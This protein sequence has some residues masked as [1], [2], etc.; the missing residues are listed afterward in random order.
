MAQLMDNSFRQEVA[1]MLR[2]RIFTRLVK[3]DLDTLVD[4]LSMVLNCVMYRFG[5]A[6]E[7]LAEHRAGLRKNDYM[8]V[9]GFVNMLL[10]FID[11]EGGTKK[12]HANLETLHDIVAKK[13]APN[14]Y[15]VCNYQYDHILTTNGEEVQ[16]R[17]DAGSAAKSY[18]VENDMTITE[19]LFDFEA[20]LLLLLRTIDEISNKLYVNWLQVQPVRL[21]NFRNTPTYRECFRYETVAGRA[22]LVAG[23]NAEPA[24]HDWIYYA[25]EAAQYRGLSIGDVYAAMAHGLYN[26]VRPVKWL[27]Y[28]GKFAGYRQPMMYVTHLQLGLPGVFDCLRASKAWL[29]LDADEKNAVADELQRYITSLETDHVT[30]PTPHSF[31]IASYLLLFMSIHYPGMDDVLEQVNAKRG[32]HDQVRAAPD[33]VK[34][35]LDGEDEIGDAAD[36]R[37]LLRDAYLTD[38]ELFQFLNDVPADHIYSFLLQSYQRLRRSWYGRRIFDLGQN[39][40]CD[41]AGEVLYLRSRSGRRSPMSYKLMYNFAKSLCVRSLDVAGGTRLYYSPSYFAMHSVEQQLFVW[42]L[43]SQHEDLR[44]VGWPSANYDFV[45]PG[46]GGKRIFINLGRYF[47]RSYG[48]DLSADDQQTLGN[49]MLLTGRKLVRDITFEY[50]IINGLLSEVMPV[51]RTPSDAHAQLQRSLS[52]EAEKESYYWITGRPYADLPPIIC[53]NEQTLD[54]EPIS[55]FQML[56]RK[57]EGMNW[58][59]FY[60]LNWVSQ[61]SFFHH[62]INNRVSFITGA[63]G[64]GKS[65]QVPKLYLYGQLMVDHRQDGAVIVSQPRIAPTINNATRISRELGVPISMH[66]RAFGKAIKTDLGYVQYRTKEDKHVVAHHFGPK[67]MVVT[68]KML[69]NDL[70][71][72][73]VFK[74]IKE[75]PGSEQV[76]DQDQFAYSAHNYYDAIMV[77][78]AHE[79]NVNMDLS[80]TLG[81]YAAYH[82]NALRLAIVSATMDD[83]EPTYRKYFMPIND[84]FKYPL[85]VNLFTTPDG[86]SHNTVDRRIH[87]SAPGHSTMYKIKEEYAPTDPANYAEAE[88]RAEAHLMQLL[89]S[90]NNGDV[91]MFSLGEAEI[92]DLVQRLNQKMPDDTICLPLY[93]TLPAAWKDVFADLRRAL[94][95][96]TTRRETLFEY[97]HGKPHLPVQAGTYKRAIIVATN[98]AE[99]SITIDSLRYVIDT[100][101]VKVSK[102]DHVTNASKLETRLITEASRLQ[103]KGRVGRVASG[104]VYYTYA[105]GSRAAVQREFPIC[106]QNGTDYMYD[107]L[108]CADNRD[109]PFMCGIDMQLTNPTELFK[110]FESEDAD[111][112]PE[113][114]RFLQANQL[115]YSMV[116]LQY[117]APFH[118]AKTLLQAQVTYAADSLHRVLLAEPRT[119]RGFQLSTLFDMDGTFYLVHPD[120]QSIDRH[121]IWHHLQ[122]IKGHPDY[123]SGLYVSTRITMFVKNLIDTG[124]VYDSS[125][126]WTLNEFLLAPHAELLSVNG[127]YL[128]YV[129][130][131]NQSIITERVSLKKSVPGRIISSLLQDLSVSEDHMQNLAAIATCLHSFCYGVDN[132]VLPMLALLK[133]CR[134][135]LTAL[136]SDMALIRGLA[137][138]PTSDLDV[139]LALARLVAPSLNAVPIEDGTMEAVQQY[140]Q[141]APRV[142]VDNFTPPIDVTVFEQ[143]GANIRAGN[144]RR[145][146]IDL[147][148]SQIGIAHLTEHAPRLQALFD[149]LHLHIAPAQFL[150][151]HLRLL[152]TL[153]ASRAVQWFVDNVHVSRSEHQPRNVLKSFMHGFGSGFLYNASGGSLVDIGTGEVACRLPANLPYGVFGEYVAIL[154]KDLAPGGQEAQLPV[155]VH[156]RTLVETCAPAVIQK[157][158]D[159]HAYYTDSLA[160]ALRGSD[161][162]HMFHTRYDVKPARNLFSLQ[163]DQ[164]QHVERALNIVRY[165]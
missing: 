10:P 59:S 143:I 73:P 60:S 122:G 30:H 84:N 71:R 23:K 69:L 88:Q 161:F 8:D 155:P 61:I 5:F 74:A 139:V 49:A 38:N 32:A 80:L 150:R 146:K 141:V 11:D 116:Y 85:D 100:G 120:E 93:S 144:L 26:D 129:Y 125:L 147:L 109:K 65:T 107:L 154:G 137:T 163:N 44:R 132:A 99:A 149:Q 15:A 156:P 108:D 77:D 4:G 62:Y 67:L 70:V 53:R 153:S 164:A 2:Q 118:V 9:L 18:D 75:A 92:K 130:A 110:W 22:S 56:L 17:L 63:T 47:K 1:D 58:M 123:N 103:R 51:E 36:I 45:V 40:V 121:P 96:V 52:P 140:R 86:E 34:R 133:L 24:T 160:A 136:A 50:L 16:R 165:T 6:E 81:R 37:R 29:L 64:T 101:Y 20:N 124:L 87:I 127:M 76:R 46:S 134:F 48:V 54:H 151:E 13:S 78:E 162:S 27:L 57:S 68:D 66:S 102:Y 3:P 79:H 159:G 128:Q 126:A 28:D 131:T 135:S 12:R 119:Q 148:T 112:V 97:I 72:S 98:I 55:Y 83:D 90:E 82:N 7:K 157:L 142:F 19:T 35:H 95:T 39:S 43:G 42:L 113:Q 114:V 115:L 138:A 89:R 145:L 158:F 33:H 152:K 21:S 105:R 104:T 111:S 31:N 106:N 41:A 94:P 14:K 117:I 25:S 91:L